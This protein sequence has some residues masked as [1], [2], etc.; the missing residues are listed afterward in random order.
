MCHANAKDEK[1]KRTALF[2][3]VLIAATPLAHADAYDCFPMCPEMPGAETKKVSLCDVSVVREAAQANARLNA[4]LKPVKDVY[5]IATNPTGFAIRMVDQHVVHIPKVVGYA[6]DPKGAVK[7]EVLKRA[8][9]AVKKEVGLADDC[10]VPASP[11][12]DSAEAD[13][14]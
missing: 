11:A 12:E 13:F 9:E 7:A 5:E 1:M 14:S 6:L 3:S 8:R 10:R 2:A 4:D